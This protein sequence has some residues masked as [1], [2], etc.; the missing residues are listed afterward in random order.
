MTSLQTVARSRGARIALAV[1]LVAL[2][3]MGFMPYVFNTISTQAE[4]NAPLI[5]LTAPVDG[6]VADLP[7]SGAYFAKPAEIKLLELSQD[8][9]AVAD[10]KAQAEIAQ[11]QM[12][13]AKRQI[14]ELADQRQRMVRR[15]AVYTGATAST[16]AATSDAQ[17][18]ALR[19]CDADRAA[20]AAARTRADALAKMGFMAGAGVE[21]AEAAAVAKDSECRS[22]AARLR[23]LQVQRNAAGAGVFINDG[24][25]D[26][27]YAEQQADR[28]VLQRQALEKMLSDATAQ[29]TQARLRLRDA[30]ERARYRAP[31]GTL[32]WAL[33]ASDGAAIRAGEP[34]LDLVDCRRR[35]V[36]V[37]VPESQAEALRPGTVA[38]VRMIGGSSWMQGEV[39]NLTGAAGRA[40]GALLA[41]RS[42][43][44]DGE[45]KIS[46]KVALPAETPSAL[47][48]ARKCDV[49][50]LAEVRFSRSI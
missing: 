1:S 23:A 4:I 43:A 45:R 42:S 6:T 26:A 7:E 39:V 18:A 40:E 30:V 22:L 31:A 16:L 28:L 14:A 17:T 19:G 33:A 47:S 2:G 27:P 21:K 12:E 10:L 36:Q 35:F 9:G 11:A 44:D 48:A 25:N 8:T 46:V 24:Y 13:L 41:A 37:A 5:R 15:A 20:L 32:V 38:K 49:G 34:V 50:R 29:Y 3:G